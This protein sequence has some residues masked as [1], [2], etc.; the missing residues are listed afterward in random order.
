MSEQRGNR[1]NEKLEISKI[2][3]DA[4]LKVT[5]GINENLSKE[6]LLELYEKVLYEYLGIDKFA[7][8]IC[9]ED[10]HSTH[11]NGFNKEVIDAI[12]WDK[13][14][15]IINGIKVVNQ[16]DVDFL[17]PFDV[18]IPIIHKHKDLAYLFLSDFEE[19][20]LE[21]SPIV[22]HLAFV[23][24]LTNIIVVAFENKRLYNESVKKATLQRELDLAKNMQ[25]LLIP[26]TLIDNSFC[27]F[28]ALYLPFSDV[29]GD[30]YDVMQ[31]S[32]NRI[33]FCI[34]DVSGKGISAAMLMSNFQANIRALLHTSKSLEELIVRLN[35]KV[36]ASG[37]LEKFITLFVGVYDPNTRLLETINCGHNPPL[38]HQ[39]N[40]TVEL[41]KGT[42]VL[43][44]FDV[45]PE[46]LVEKNTLLP[47]A[48]LL[49]YTDGISEITNSSGEEFGTAELINILSDYPPKQITE[50]VK[51]RADEFRGS[52]ILPDDITLLSCIFF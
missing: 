40:E 33:G 16:N 21:V 41:K 46:I 15:S 38:L 42:T 10:L 4:L 32:N 35:K 36:M 34:A 6:E 5:N 14:G 20:K 31:L 49:C 26:N 28:D 37:G 23:Q 52:S 19:E 8:F 24:T 29:G 51:K 7:L 9:S 18:V 22:R 25:Q 50:M 2:K 11:I 13:I 30:Y 17:K 39:N 3:L 45:L 12:Q 47:N 48:K 1:T 44:M 27:Q 43:G